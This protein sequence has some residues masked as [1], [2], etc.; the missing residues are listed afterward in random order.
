MFWVLMGY[1]IIEYV[2]PQFFVP[3]I[4]IIRPGLIFGSVLFVF[5]VT[6]GLKTITS[7]K[8]ARLIV[9]FSALV[10][11]WVPFAVNNFHAFNTAKG[12]ILHTFALVVPILTLVRTPQLLRRLA[13]FFVSV[14]TY[15]ALFA[16]THGGRGPGSFIS[17]ENDAAL[18]ILTGLPFAFYLTASPRISRFGSIMLYAAFGI[19]TIGVVA[20]SSRGGFIGLAAVVGC[21]IWFS[22]KRVKAIVALV[23]LGVAVLPF[24][25]EEYYAEVQSITDDTD[26]TRLDRFHSWEMG[27]YMYID[28]PVVGIGPANYPWRVNEW[29][30]KVPMDD[31][32]SRRGHGGRVAHSLYFTLLPELGTVGTVLYVWLLFLTVRACTGIRKIPSDPEDDV[33]EYK[34]YAKAL[35]TAI[36]GFLIS[37]TF[38]SVLYY[39][40]LWFLAAMAAVLSHVCANSTG[41]AA[42]VAE[43]AKPSLGR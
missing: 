15:V 31:R 37:G 34:L 9:A 3:A 7:N 38:I 25:P 40:E 5:S 20:T 12:M 13:G 16:M 21:L 6:V 35:L 29:E 33:T 39:P 30:A 43:A 1:M 27:W 36:A 11:L 22:E 18:F 14:T 10:V 17:D 8:I 23:M 24:V 2:R 26:G 4:G 42:D 41:R 19:M 32:I 28:N